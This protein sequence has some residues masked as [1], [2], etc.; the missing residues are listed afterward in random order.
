MQLATTAA[1]GAAAARPTSFQ[2][3]VGT[4][5]TQLD[6]ALAREDDTTETDLTFAAIDGAD[7]ILRS[8]QKRTASDEAKSDMWDAAAMLQDARDVI[9]TNWSME[10]PHIEVGYGNI[11]RDAVHKAVDLLNQSIAEA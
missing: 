11:G 9:A 2:R 8:A 7:D 5:V 10:P 1:L 4:L 6:A 3:Q